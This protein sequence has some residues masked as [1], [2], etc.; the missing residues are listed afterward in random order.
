MLVTLSLC[1]NRKYTMQLKNN[2][3]ENY[4]CKRTEF[5]HWRRS[6]LCA[7]VFNPQAGTGKCWIHPN[8]WCGLTITRKRLQQLKENKKELYYTS[9]SEIK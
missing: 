7:S 8:M 5:T 3:Y 1:W 6:S 2:L 4:N 9:V